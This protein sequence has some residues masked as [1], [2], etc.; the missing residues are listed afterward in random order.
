MDCPCLF[1]SLCFLKKSSLIMI[2]WLGD[3]ATEH[4]FYKHLISSLILSSNY[5]K[6]TSVGGGAGRN[7]FHRKI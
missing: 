5:N 2:S 7:V 6:V 4:I 1:I 3:R